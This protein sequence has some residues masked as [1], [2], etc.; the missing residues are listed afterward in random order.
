MGNEMNPCSWPQV[1]GS[2]IGVTSKGLL[3][4]PILN[5]MTGGQRIQLFKKGTSSSLSCILGWGTKS[6][7]KKARAHAI[8]YDLPYISVEDGFLRSVGLGV[9]G[10]LP[11]SIVF[12]IHG[13]YYDAT[14]TSNLEVVLEVSDFQEN[15][16]LMVMAHHAILEIRE[17]HISKYNAA[18]DVPSRV[19]PTSERTRVLIIAQTKGDQSIRYGFT[20][21]ITTL[22]IVKS[23][24]REHPNAEFFLK[25]HPDV[26]SGKKKSDFDPKAVSQYCTIISEDWNPISL[27][28][29][30]DVIYTKTSQMGFEALL[31]GKKVVCFGMPFYAGWGLTD[32]RVSCSRRTRKRTVEEVFAAAYILYTHYYNPYT[33]KQSDILDTIHTLRK[34]RNISR[35][36]AGRIYCFGFSGW[37]RGYIRLFLR[38]EQKNKVVFCQSLKQAIRKGLDISGK[39]LVWGRDTYSDIEAFA[40]DNGIVINRVEDG[41]IRS[42][43]LGSDLTKPYSLVVDSRGIYFDPTKESDLEHLLSTYDFS[44]HPDLLDRSIVIQK[45]ICN[46]KLSK[47]NGLP[48]NEL[49]VDRSSCDKVILIP[50]QVEDDASI[51]FGG[52]GV[53][54]RSL[55]E[56]VRR[57]TP[58]A[59]VIYKPHPDVVA[60]NRNGHVD[61]DFLDLSCDM[62][63]SEAS[64]D[65]CLAVA[66]E[67]HTITSLCGFD[68]LL[69]GKKVHTYGLPFYAGWGLTTDKHVCPRRQRELSLNELVAGVLLLY[70]RYIH[71]QTGDFCELELL[72][73]SLKKEQERYFSSPVYRWMKGARDLPLRFVRRLY[74][75]LLN[76]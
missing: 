66:D 64:I 50:G 73:E 4:H 38:S 46:S 27:L 10:A 62:V 47:Y 21:G 18:P 5:A 1:L 74:E 17:H 23:A 39:V 68:A 65:S 41:F 29:K 53:T 7:T 57:E 51:R 54:N 24:Q 67:V 45:M 71:P 8:K 16:T 25:V 28:K 31:L 49:I 35:D 32:D 6:N 30:M 72:L 48:H 60:G 34:Y 19:F 69:R 13:I 63:V 20:G 11:F 15:K 3:G 26:L 70:P 14:H 58:N 12:D 37:K 44:A 61:P 42:V 36:N 43:S 59:Y 52:Y 56:M 33:G 22:D 76:Y 55:L 2:C 75:G 40:N 9:H